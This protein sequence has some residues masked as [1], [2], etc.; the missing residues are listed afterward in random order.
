MKNTLT[1]LF[2]RAYLLSLCHETSVMMQDLRFSWWWCFKLRSSGSWCHIVLWY[3]TN[4]S[5]V[6]AAPICRC[7]DLWNIGILP[8]CCM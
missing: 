5:E 7:M 1:I 6:H 3:D 8:Q 2:E 4:A